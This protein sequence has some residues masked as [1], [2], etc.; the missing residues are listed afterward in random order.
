MAANRLPPDFKEFLKLLNSHKVE[1]LLIGGYAVAYHGY[2]RPTGDMDIWIAVNPENADRVS[3]TLVQFGFKAADVP[4]SLF[5]EKGRIARMGMPPMRLE[6]VTAISG[7]EF[8][9]CYARRISAKIDGVP[10]NLIGLDDLK[11]NKKAS[12]RHKDLNDLE[13]LP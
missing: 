7:V 11:I 3:R 13:Q 10:V 4:A 5:Q 6:V 1:Y 12:G 9:V 8:E 2:P